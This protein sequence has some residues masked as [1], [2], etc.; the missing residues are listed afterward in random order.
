MTLHD[1]LDY[2]DTLLNGFEAHDLRRE[3]QD[4]KRRLAEMEGRLRETQRCSSGSNGVKELR[5]R[6]AQTDKYENLYAISLR[7]NEILN[8]KLK[9][10]GG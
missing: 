2:E 7:R 4:L 8:R 5:A 10:L 1:T 6:A 9:E 3:N